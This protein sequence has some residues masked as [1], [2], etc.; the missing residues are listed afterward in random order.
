MDE[1]AP[2]YL[3][4]SCP[5]CGSTNTRRSMRAKSDTMLLRRELFQSPY[6]CVDCDHYFF[7]FRVPR[8]PRPRKS[9]GSGPKIRI[10]GAD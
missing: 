5:N 2:E 9:A 4:P 8:P 1:L 10:P 7:G 6:R 3:L